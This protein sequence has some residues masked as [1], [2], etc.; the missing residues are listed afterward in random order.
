MAGTQ[1]GQQIILGHVCCYA[2]DFHILYRIFSQIRN[3]LH[4]PPDLY[5]STTNNSSITLEAQTQADIFFA[6][7]YCS[8][9]LDKQNIF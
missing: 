1:R 5:Y 7:H 3:F 2:W 9:S 8:D 6:S 4:R